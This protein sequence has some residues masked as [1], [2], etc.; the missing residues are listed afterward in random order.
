MFIFSAGLLNLSKKKKRSTISYFPMVD[1]LITRLKKSLI[2]VL[3]RWIIHFNLL[4]CT[5]DWWVRDFIHFIRLFFFNVDP[6]L[7]INLHI[8]HRKQ[9]LPKYSRTDDNCSVK[10]QSTH[11]IYLESDTHLLRLGS[12]VLLIF[13]SNRKQER[14]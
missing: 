10:G 6:P 14:H 11:Q 4:Y 12:S 9:Y 13:A 2:N 5:D 8:I 3:D 1:W 7:Y